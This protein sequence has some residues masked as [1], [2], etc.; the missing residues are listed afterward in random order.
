MYFFFFLTLI[1]SILH[2]GMNGE[3]R[4]GFKQDKYVDSPKVLPNKRDE[5]RHLHYFK[6]I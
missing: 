3:G 4:L 6:S 1:P 2:A 5:K